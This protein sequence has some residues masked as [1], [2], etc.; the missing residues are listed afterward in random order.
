MLCPFDASVDL[1][2]VA[3]TLGRRTCFAA[4]PSPKSQGLVFS[5]ASALGELGRIVQKF[6]NRGS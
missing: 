2:L 4:E 5:S 1:P 6:G 3:E